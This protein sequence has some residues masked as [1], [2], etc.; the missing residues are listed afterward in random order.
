M[1]I[2]GRGQLGTFWGHFPKGIGLGTW[3]HWPYIEGHVPVPYPQT[4][5]PLC[6]GH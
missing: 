2:W 5:N 1:R 6:W 3:G 4:R